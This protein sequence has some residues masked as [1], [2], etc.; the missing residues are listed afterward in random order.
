MKIVIG[1]A[2]S[3]IALAFAPVVQTPPTCETCST[4]S[5]GWTSLPED[6]RAVTDSLTC[7]AQSTHCSVSGTLTV[8]T[9]C[10]SQDHCL[11]FFSITNC[12]TPIVAYTNNAPAQSYSAGSSDDILC[13]SSPNCGRGIGVQFWT[14]AGASEGAACQG[15][16]NALYSHNFLCQ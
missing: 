5:V 3:L 15:S 16:A 2:L 6:C 11:Q 8:D 9:W 12:G 14:T 13:Q 7:S 10:E 4:A 1:L